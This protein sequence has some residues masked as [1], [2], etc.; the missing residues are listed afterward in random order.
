MNRT[1]SPITLSLLA[2][3]LLLLTP[4]TLSASSHGHAGHGTMADQMGH[5]GHVGQT[6]QAGQVGQAEQ[7]GQMGQM[8]HGAAAGQEM[9][10]KVVSTPAE[11]VAVAADRKSL[12]IDHPPIPALGWPAMAMSMPLADPALAEGLAAGDRVT[13]EISR[14]SATEYVIS[15]LTKK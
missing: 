9:A 10:A 5:G 1:P 14:K 8:G 4:P 7:I 2:A 11:I 15:G 6:G 12:E 13:L 3:A